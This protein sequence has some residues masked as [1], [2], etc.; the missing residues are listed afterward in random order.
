MIE[1]PSGRVPKKALRWGLTRIEA[2]GGGK[3]FWWM[4]LMVWE[5]LGIYRPRIRVG[6]LPGGPQANPPPRARPEGLWTPRRSSNPNLC[7]INSQIFPNHQRHPPKYFSAAASLYSREIHLRAF[8]GNLP[9]GDSVMEG[10]YINLAALA[11]MCG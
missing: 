6:G 9:E 7:T 4:P 8:F 2:C 11:M 3:E 10:L 5:Y 1:S